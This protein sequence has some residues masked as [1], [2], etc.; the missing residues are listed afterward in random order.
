MDF[1]KYQ[2]EHNGLYYKHKLSMNL[3][4][5]TYAKHTHNMYELLYFVSGDVTQVIEDRRYKLKSGDLVLIPPQK[6]H[7][8]EINSTSDYERY[9]I[10]FDAQMLNI[11]NISYFGK[12]VF[13]FNLID[14]PI[15]REILQ[16]TDYYFQNF[17]SDDFV[18]IMTHLLCELLWVLRLSSH[19]RDVE[20]FAA[21]NPTLSEA[22]HYINENLAKLSDM[23]EVAKE[24][25]VSPSYLFRLF[26]RDLHQT[27]K[28]Y[29]TDK[30]LL[31]AHSKIVDGERP[32]D[33]Y[34]ACGF[35][36]YTAFYRNYIR[37]FGYSP[38]E[39]IIKIN[40]NRTNRVCKKL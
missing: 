17:Q 35:G 6:Y 14:V 13:V 36:D 7:F 39:T 29:I 33:V 16:K 5:S 38:S 20:P 26:K 25:F 9:N 40:N 30:R 1:D 34:A 21:M 23:D 27:P 15:A 2:L 24:C 22:L 19:K 4:S 11:D 12:E 31:M 3:P 28:K 10:L 18:S 32:T 37:F 8:V